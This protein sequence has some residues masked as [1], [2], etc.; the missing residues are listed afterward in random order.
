MRQSINS[1]LWIQWDDYTHEQTTYIVFC[2]LRLATCSS[3][4]SIADFIIP[5]ECIFTRTGFSY[6]VFIPLT[7]IDCIRNQRH[8]SRKESSVFN[9]SLRRNNAEI[10]T[11]YR[12]IKLSLNSSHN[13]NKQR[14]RAINRTQC[15]RMDRVWHCDSIGCV[16][17]LFIHCTPLCPSCRWIALCVSVD[18]ACATLRFLFI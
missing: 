8:L 7:Y 3:W 2:K 17:L 5:F 18:K 10:I 6:I 9:F 11:I 13:E 16:A 4:M 14:S 15:I 12:H 1:E